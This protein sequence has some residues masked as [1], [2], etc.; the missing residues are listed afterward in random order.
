MTIAT[1]YHVKWK[2]RDR[3][4][5]T[6]A[7]WNDDAV[8]DKLIHAPAAWNGRC[9]V[10]RVVHLVT[11]VAIL[12]RWCVTIQFH[13]HRIRRIRVGEHKRHRQLYR[14][15]N[16]HCRTPH[17]SINNSRSSRTIIILSSHVRIT[18][19]NSIN[20]NWFTVIIFRRR[21]HSNKRQTLLKMN[22]VV[23]IEKRLKT[24]TECIIC[25]L[26]GIRAKMMMCHANCRCPVWIWLNRW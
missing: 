17:R 11:T 10:D 9:I 16:I 22:I 20:K 6:P 8:S 4:L 7:L 26:H 14:F 24:I 12:I 2:M 3:D 1:V 18:I 21:W 25:R 5:V 13:P 15:G 19:T 23:W